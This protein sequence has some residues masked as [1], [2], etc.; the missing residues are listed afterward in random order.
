MFFDIFEFRGKLWAD[1]KIHK[2]VVG[3][4]QAQDK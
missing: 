3:L 4:R 1:F 2:I